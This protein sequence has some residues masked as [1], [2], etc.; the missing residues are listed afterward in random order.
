LAN[1][2]Q[3]LDEFGER[4]RN[5]Y[6]SDRGPD[7]FVR[8]KENYIVTRDTTGTTHGSTYDYD[9]IVPIIFAGP[10]VAKGNYKDRILTIDLAPTLAALLRIPIDGKMDGKIAK[11]ALDRCA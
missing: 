4:F 11:I 9:C 2:N 5:C 7:L 10:G 3:E 6:H 1:K 8:F